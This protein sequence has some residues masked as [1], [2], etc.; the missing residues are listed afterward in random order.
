MYI[1]NDRTQT[2]IIDRSHHV[3][4]RMKLLL[5]QTN[6][7]LIT[8]ENSQLRTKHADIA[9]QLQMT[10]T[11]CI[12]TIPSQQYLDRAMK[13]LSEYVFILAGPFDRQQTCQSSVNADQLSHAADQLNQATNDLVVCT[14]TGVL[15]DLATTSTRFSQ[16]FADFLH[17]S[18][19]YVHYHHQQEDDKRSHILITLKNVHTSSNQLLER[20]KSVSLEPMT[21]ENDTKQQLAN[22]AR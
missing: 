9:Q 22:A 10:L 19:D 21:N 3:L 16:A 8:P 6:M 4:Q 14:R 15:D 13:Q 12:D 5:E 17:N 2:M 7:I 1:D 20:A 18:L 11:L